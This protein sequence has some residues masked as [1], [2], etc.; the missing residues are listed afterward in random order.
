MILKWIWEVRWFEAIV[1]DFYKEFGSIGTWWTTY[2]I[3]YISIWKFFS[4]Q[5]NE[6]VLNLRTCID[7]LVFYSLEPV[8]KIILRGPFQKRL[9]LLIY[10]LSIKSAIYSKSTRRL[11]YFLTHCGWHDDRRIPL[12]KGQECGNSFCAVKSYT[13]RISI[14]EYS[15][16]SYNRSLTL[17]NIRKACWPPFT[18]N[19]VLSI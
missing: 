7:D 16:Y 4:I 2:Q 8:Q 3:H 15:P 18:K 17:G 12:G 10:K 6:N 13:F 19:A 11:E 1:N 5:P 14:M 9:R